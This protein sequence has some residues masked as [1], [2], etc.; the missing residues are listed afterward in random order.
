VAQGLCDVA[1]A[2]KYM[3]G[4]AVVNR[5]LGRRWISRVCNLMVRALMNPRIRDYS[6]GYR[7]Y[8]RTAAEA[9]AQTRIRYGSPIYLSEVLGLWIARGFRIREFQTTYVGR[10]EGESK[11]RIIDLVKAA[12]AVFE[13][14]LRVHL[15]G[16]AAEHRVLGDAPAAVSKNSQ[17]KQQVT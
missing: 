5:P 17:S 12:I 14:A 6:N 13:I 16:F 10:G 9:I 1:I 3:P 15:I 2:S 11:L 8:S 4:S 7:F